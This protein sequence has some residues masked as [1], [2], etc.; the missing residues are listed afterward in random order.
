MATKTLTI[1]EDAYERLA[2]TKEENES[3]SEVI[4]RIT[5]K[6]SLLSMAGILSEQEADR[7]EQRIKNMRAK[8]RQKLLHIRQELQ[9]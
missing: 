4:N 5:N 2:A 9:E 7:I 8:S 3:F 6:V 1:T